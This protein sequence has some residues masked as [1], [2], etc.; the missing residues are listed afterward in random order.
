MEK[1]F[2]IKELKNMIKAIKNDNPHYN[3]RIKDYACGIFKFD[4]CTLI[5]H[6]HIGIKE[7]KNIEY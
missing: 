3:K 5:K 2:S 7:Y 4:D 1:I 6:R